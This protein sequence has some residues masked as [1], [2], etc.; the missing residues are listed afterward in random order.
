MPQTVPYHCI[1]PHA[2]EPRL[3]LLP[4]VGG[5]EPPTIDVPIGPLVD[6]VGSLA[7]VLQ[8]QLNSGVAVVRHIPDPETVWCELEILDAAWQPSR[9]A[10]WAD[11]DELCRLVLGLPEHRTLLISWLEEHERGQS[12][13]LRAPWERRGWFGAASTWIL[14][15]LTLLAITPTGPITQ[16]KAA[17]PCSSILRV[18]ATTG[19]LYFKAVYDRPPSEPAVI[20]ALAKR[21]P[22]NVP[23]IL[24]TDQARRWMLMR[25]IGGVP[26]TEAPEHYWLEAV[27][28]FATM[29]ISAGEDLSRWRSLDCPDRTLE[30]LVATAEHLCGDTIALQAEHPYGLA[31]SEVADLRSLVPLLRRKAEQLASYSLSNAIVQQ[32][33]RPANVAVSGSTCV[34]FDWSDTVI[35][36]PFFSMTRFLNFVPRT[37]HALRHSLRDAYLEQWTDLL[38]MS[39]LL[40]AFEL[41]RQLNALYVGV[42]WYLELPYLE[43]DSGWARELTQAVPDQMRDVLAM[44]AS[45]PPDAR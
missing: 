1:V 7:Q 24:A 20:S 23:V 31:D 16:R 29:Q 37:A 36:H 43:P 19:D 11:S 27:R 9:G 32:D 34:L 10:R 18:P 41:A 28:L 8:A 26:L 21:W 5:W 22:A 2:A 45:L 3:L 13:Q 44:V 12:S 42:R 15:Q 4:A 17:W 39:L 33:F 30:T 25:D 38:P 35:G 6:N 40:E 14:D